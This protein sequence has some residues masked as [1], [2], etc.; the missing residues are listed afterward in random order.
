MN[1]E[2]FKYLSKI[3]NFKKT[4]KNCSIEENSSLTLK[5]RYTH[6]RFKEI[7][8]NHEITLMGLRQQEHLRWQLKIEKQKNK[9]S[10]GILITEL[11]DRQ[12]ENVTDEEISLLLLKYC[13]I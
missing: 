9:W 5:S 7:E 10:L 2:K 13:S 6:P 4:L 8:I 12:I 3:E 11:N 1:K